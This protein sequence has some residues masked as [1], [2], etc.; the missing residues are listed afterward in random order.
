[1]NSADQGQVA[2][3]GR[4]VTSPYASHPPRA[5]AASHAHRPHRASVGGRRSSPLDDVNAIVWDP[6]WTGEFLDLLSVLT[7]LVSLE[8]QQADI[9][10]SILA[11]GLTTMDDL[12]GAGVRWPQSR[13]NRK[14]RFSLDSALPT[15]DDTLM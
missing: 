4:S 3:G 14:P 11:S 15:G 9:L 5:R 10:E 12:S 13:A 1:M 7:R 6:D 2:R 8:P